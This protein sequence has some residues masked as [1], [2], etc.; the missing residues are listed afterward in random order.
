MDA[1]QS[2]FGSLP[3]VSVMI[4]RISQHEPEIVINR[5]RDGKNL[6]I[7]IPLD[8]SSKDNDILG[9]EMKTEGHWQ[10]NSLSVDFSGSRLGRQVSYHENWTMASDGQSFKVARHLVS[11]RGET[12][13]TILFV[14]Q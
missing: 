6:I 13:Q 8:G 1:A 7:D 10:G 9:L 4:D 2:D 12:D 14:K 3:P 5:A 11:P